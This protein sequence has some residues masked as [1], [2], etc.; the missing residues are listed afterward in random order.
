M[1]ILFTGRG[2]KAG[3]WKIRGEQLGKGSRV[4]PNARPEDIRKADVTVVVKRLTPELLHNLKGSKWIWDVVDAYPQPACST[5][6]QKQA[7]KWFHSLLSQYKPSGVIFPTRRMADDCNI[8]LPETVIYHHHWPEIEV[9]P[10]REEVKSVGYEGSLRYLGRWGEIITREC[11]RR[12]WDFYLNSGKH[13]QFDI[14]VAFRDKPGYVQTHW[15]SNVKLANAHGSG[16]PFI[17]QRESGYLETRTGFECWADSKVELV[18]AFDQLDYETRLA[19]Q[20]AFLVSA[21]T[22]S[23]SKKQLEDFC[24]EIL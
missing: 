13:A 9:N 3:S 8:D 17:G 7:V 18:K 2:G 20:K 1:G 14:C 11:E 22:V 23:D 16:T 5:W 24:A 12:G 4:K 19:T 21:I 6:S 15:K 10:I